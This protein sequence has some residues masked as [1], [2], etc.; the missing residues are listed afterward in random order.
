M[1][2]LLAKVKNRS[3]NTSEAYKKIISDESVY[4]TPYNLAD[5][6]E[7]NPN[8]LLENNQ[9]YKISNFSE[10]DFCTNL[11]KEDSIDSVDFDMLSQEDFAKIDYI[12]SW[13]G[14]YFYFQKVRPAQLVVKKRIIFG[15]QYKYD[16]NSKSVVINMFPDAVYDKNNDI[17][18]FQRLEP[19]ATIFRGID[20]LYREATEQETAAF[21]QNNFIS[22]NNDF[23]AK[24]V[25][26][27]VRKKIAL[28]TNVLNSFDDERKREMI[29][30]IKTNAEL[31]YENNSFSI[32]NEEDLKKLLFGISERYYE[33]PVSKERRIANSIIPLTSN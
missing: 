24:K 30:Y 17:L 18:F 4:S 6:I 15:D 9:W 19:I 22:L 13:E 2:Q 7:Y 11:L 8:T 33:A 5:C 25:N 20:V 29:E 1:N 27:S 10:Q 26:K 12:C 32:S 21:L 31:T 28:A 23:N 3:K 16:A 14:D